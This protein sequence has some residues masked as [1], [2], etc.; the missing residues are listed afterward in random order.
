M[1]NYSLLLALGIVL[2]AS[3]NDPEELSSQ[4]EIVSFTVEGQTSPATILS[5]AGTIHVWVD[6]N[7]NLSE[8]APVI[9]VSEKA[10]ITPASGQTMDFSQGEVTYTVT[11]QD[12]STKVWKATVETEKSNEAN[13]LSFYIKR[14]KSEALIGDSTIS[15]EMKIGTD[16]TSLAP[17]ITISPKATISPASGQAVDFS[18]GP[19]VYS[20]T[21]EDGHTKHWTVTVT[22]EKIYEANILSFTIPDQV[23]ET[24]FENSY[25]YLEVPVG[26][27]LTSVVPTITITEGTTIEPQSGV[28][29]N[30]ATTGYIDY[31]V[32]TEVGSSKS[33]R[34]YVAEEVIDADHPNIQYIG[35]VD[36]SNPKKPKL[37]APGSTIKTKFKG[38]FCQIILNDQELYG[39]Y[40]NYL[41]IIVDGTQSTRIQTT[42][43][44][45]TINIVSGLSDGEHT[46]QITKDTE[47]GIGYIE[48]LGF[49]CDEL[50]APDPLPERRIEFI[51]NSITCGYGNDDSQKACG[52]GEWYDQH[53][54]YLAYGPE[55]ARRLNSQWMLTSVSGI[56]MIHSCC[57][58][59]YEMPD[60][61]HSVSL[62]TTG[63]S[64][65]FTK[66]PADIVTVCLGQ[67]DGIQD[68][69]AFCSAYVSFIGI[70]RSKYPD[71]NI[72]CLTS[73]MADNNLYNS[74]V[75]Y[76]TGIINHM[77]NAGDNNV[78]K[79]HL[80]HNLT[81]GCD[82]H[83]NASQ[84]QIVADE[85]E[86]FF[87]TQFG[88]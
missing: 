25:I 56:G 16:L 50:L 78:W 71:A 51:G 22:A 10:T 61:Y 76:L 7:T 46:L 58:I 55:V 67:N 72:V 14:Q 8:V 6:T 35:R 18:A 37:Y 63:T 68:S 19:V 28:A 15:L 9:T 43:K 59:T 77:N 74:Q 83:P 24:V 38:T 81:G 85:L 47:A 49:R 65:D 30:F 45:N 64:W 54:A 69:T 5:E 20:V 13:I 41:Q 39:S 70:I 2:N 29:V 11:A 44:N 12:N 27:N 42:T 26:Y 79:L 62:T 40:H 4:K 88:W 87:K 80:T 82:Y 21:A 3:C 52:S 73:P 32:T 31:K 34:V 60:V 86:T 84:H 75:N 33:W 17:E 48:F 23:G 36:F 57:D 53:N 66:Y 1:K